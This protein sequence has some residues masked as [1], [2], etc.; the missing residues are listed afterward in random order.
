MGLETTV[1]G[2]SDGSEE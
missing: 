2:I 1:T